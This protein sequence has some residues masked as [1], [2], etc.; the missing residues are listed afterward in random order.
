MLH[1]TREI[2]DFGSFEVK[3][4]WLGDML[5]Q[6]LLGEFWAIKPAS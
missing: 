1:G 5:S 2:H 4:G 6:E 3:A